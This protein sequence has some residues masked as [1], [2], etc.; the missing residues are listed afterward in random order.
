MQRYAI[1]LHFEEKAESPIEAAQQVARWLG[2]NQPV[3][4]AI[5]DETGTDHDL[6][7][8]GDNADTATPVF[9]ETL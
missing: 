7:M 9:E 6:T 3:Y 4:Y 5:T 1:S 8:E 2:T